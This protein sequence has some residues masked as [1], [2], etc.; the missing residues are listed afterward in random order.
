MKLEDLFDLEVYGLPDIMPR[1]KFNPAVL[2]DLPQYFYNP[3]YP[4]YV[5]KGREGHVFQDVRDMV[6][7]SERLWEK[8]LGDKDLDV[9]SERVLV[10]KSRCQETLDMIVATLREKKKK[11]LDARISSYKALVKTIGTGHAE[12]QKMLADLQKQYDELY[13]ESDTRKIEARTENLKTLAKERDLILDKARLNGQ[14]ISSLEVQ[15]QLLDAEESAY[16]RLIGSQDNLIDGTS[17]EEKERW[18]ILQSAKEQ[19]KTETELWTAQ[20]KAINA[21]GGDGENGLQAQ[22]KLLDE[23]TKKALKNEETL[24]IKEAEKEGNLEEARRIRLEASKRA[25]DE[26]LKQRLEGIDAAYAQEK[27][28]I[29]KTQKLVQQSTIESSTER[30]K[31]I[32]T[33]EGDVKNGGVAVAQKLREGIALSE[34]EEATFPYFLTKVREEEDKIR[35]N[36]NV[37]L[38][39]RYAEAE[40]LRTEAIGKAA[41][42][43]ETMT[44]IA[45]LEVAPPKSSHTDTAYG[46]FSSLI[47][48]FRTAGEDLEGMWGGIL[49]EMDA[50][51]VNAMKNMADRITSVT[52]GTFNTVVGFVKA[53]QELNHADAMNTL[54]ERQAD[55]EDQRRVDQEKLESGEMTE[56]QMVEAAKERA[57]EELK[58]KHEMARED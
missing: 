29:D 52:E 58:I 11:L 25:I 42:D 22:A 54:N 56:E 12:E 10:A 21:A 36:A 30:E 8:V 1:N 26:E 9:E 28:S 40:R 41:A 47:D 37:D 34:K 57:K 27:A 49:D 53:I 3:N 50:K 14:D 33:I 55:L 46:N 2:G 48:A 7:L 32:K 45:E 16:Y 38:Q 31:Y 44:K 15:K 24:A 6:Q 17:K 35:A 13:G 43:T 51:T 19:L 18:E 5:F 39:D 20:Q 23:I 4:K